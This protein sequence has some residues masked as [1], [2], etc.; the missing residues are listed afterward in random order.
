MN[1]RT[2][3][4]A[5]ILIVIICILS[6]IYVIVNVRE[7]K[8]NA[9]IPLKSYINYHRPPVLIEDIS[10][11]MTFDYINKMF[12]LPPEYLKQTLN[13]NDKRYPVITISQYSRK[14][15]IKTNLAITNVQDAVKSYL[16]SLTPKS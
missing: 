2:K 8:N 1:L 14:E 11:W 15:K 10:P 7:L 5:L 12:N 9:Y 16:A 4:I 6:W 3:K 13:I